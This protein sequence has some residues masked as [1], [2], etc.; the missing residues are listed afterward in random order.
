ML[1]IQISKIP[2]AWMSNS[3][4]LIGLLI[5]ACLCCGTWWTSQRVQILKSGSLSERRRKE[6][7]L[8]KMKTWKIYFSTWCNEIYIVYFFFTGIPSCLVLKKVQ[9][10]ASYQ[11]SFFSRQDALHYSLLRKPIFRTKFRA[12]TFPC[13][14]YNSKFFPR[15]THSHC[16]WNAKNTRQKDKENTDSKE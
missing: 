10:S 4:W 9:L 11:F 15:N 3:N 8:G 13:C 7:Y 6:V 14:D 2:K 1:P 16:S 5:H 12:G